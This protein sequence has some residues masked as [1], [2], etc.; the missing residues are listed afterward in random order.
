MEENT[1]STMVQMVLNGDSM[2][3]K[4]YKF[5]VG[6]KV[7]TTEGETGKITHICTC[8]NCNS[9]GFHELFWVND[10]NTEDCITKYQAETGFNGFYQIGSYRFNDF[11]KDEVL[12]DMAYHEEE[13]KRLK[14]QL[15]LIEELDNNMTHFDKIKNMNIDELA[16]YFADTSA[17]PY[18]ACYVCEHDYGMYCNS[19]VACTEEYRAKVYKAWLEKEVVK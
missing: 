14:K 12:R 6:D 10:Y 9:R 19:P 17:F 8:D 7:I 18:S 15:K 4:D 2:N 16:K 3:I 1:E 5:E 13:L 11:D